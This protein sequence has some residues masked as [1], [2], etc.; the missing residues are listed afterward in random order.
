MNY[1]ASILIVE[2]EVLIAE[3]LKDT[4]ISVGFSQIGLVHSKSDALKV[5]ESTNL[6]LILLDIR[7]KDE[8]DGISIA[9]TISKTCKTPF[10]FITAH[11]DK[12]IV[13]KALHTQPEAYLT[14]P[15]K[16]MD[17][18]AATSLALA[19]TQ[20]AAGQQ[21]FAFKDGYAVVTL[22]CGDIL[23]IESEGNYISVVTEERKYTV[24]HSLEWC[25]QNL[26]AG[27]F[28][29]IHRSFIV[30]VEKI[31]KSSSR[32]VQIGQKVIP[33]SRPKSND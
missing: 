26:P 19:Q 23:Y 22:F 3:Y 2:D 15:F 18:F 21:K 29:R 27:A 7:M 6:D 10:I 32:S 12:D 5:I 16:K 13:Q 1:D 11:S 20:R 28:R 24:R 17:V 30:N 14:K 25:L 4:L 33:K 8:L 9:E 31:E